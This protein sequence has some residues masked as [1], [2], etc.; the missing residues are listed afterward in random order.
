[1]SAKKSTNRV[2]KLT[3]ILGAIVASTFLG[4]PALAQKNDS[5]DPNYGTSYP[6]N[7]VPLNSN[8][9]NNQNSNSIN[10]RNQ[11]SN[12]NR[13]DS[14]RQT[15]ASY[16]NGPSGENTNAPDDSQFRND[17]V[18]PNYGTSYP[19]NA[20]PLNG[21]QNQ[22]QINN[23]N[24][25]NQSNY[26]ERQTNYSPAQ[27]SVDCSSMS[28]SYNSSSYSSSAQAQM[29]GATPGM[30]QFPNQ[31]DPRTGMSQNDMSQNSGMERST[32]YDQSSSMGRSNSR[33]M[34]A[35]DSR[36]ETTQYGNVL[37][38][39]GATTGGESRQLLTAADGGYPTSRPIGFR[40]RASQ[41]AYNLSTPGLQ[42]V[43]YGDVLAG[44]GSTT[45]G[46]S[47]QMLM[48]AGDVSREGQPNNYRQTGYQS[49]SIQC[50]PGMMQ[51]NLN[52]ND[53]DRQMMNPNQ[54]L[55]NTNDQRSPGSSY[56]GSTAPNPDSTGTYEN[57]RQ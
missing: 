11:P 4:L 20:V 25:Q 13:V 43:Q 44:G 42:A 30:R 2:R 24:N 54:N 14:G 51:R 36:A 9:N 41:E 57:R 49:S 3:S 26:R 8:Q 1:M 28:Q 21:N 34:S 45:G 56:D 16:S 50:P 7:A 39:G 23:Q 17:S 52:N 12:Q 29:N 40:F 31:A 47:R 53:Q 22:N 5:V 19:D 18:D 15:P 55:N 38:T 35:P 37:S 48:A 27:G 33:A 46:G 10:H 32:G 6:D